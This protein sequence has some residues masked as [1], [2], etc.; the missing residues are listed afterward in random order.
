M[1]AIYK[2]FKA[3]EPNIY[4]KEYVWIYNYDRIT[5]FNLGSQ[6]DGAIIARFYNAVYYDLYREPFSSNE[7]VVLFL[8]KGKKS[9]I[10]R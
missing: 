2:Y 1:K 8:E 10:G 5:S 7:L 9:K 4:I 3:Y 6:S